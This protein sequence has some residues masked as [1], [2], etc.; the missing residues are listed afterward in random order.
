MYIIESVKS[1]LNHKMRNIYIYIYIKYS[2]YFMIHI[3][4]VVL[5]DN[6]LGLNLF[7]HK[8]LGLILINYSLLIGLK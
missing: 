8:L 2:S 1:N 3:Y 6:L 7:K 5:H 4:F